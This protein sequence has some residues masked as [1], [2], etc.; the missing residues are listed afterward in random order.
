MNEIESKFYNSFISLFDGKIKTYSK[1][2]CADIKYYLMKD[3]EYENH[4]ILETDNIY[5]RQGI[6]TDFFIYT[7][8]DNACDISGYKPDILI[9]DN[10]ERGY[11]IE[12]DGFQ[13]HEKTVEQAINDRKKDRVYLKNRVIPIRFLG[14]EVFHESFACAEET[15]KIILE[16]EISVIYN[17]NYEWIEYQLNQNDK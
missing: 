7:N 6:R 5:N 4:Y 9:V 17:S 10:T 3:K 13:W 14:K 2:D 11:A 8:E 12:I 16:N 15:I 1:E